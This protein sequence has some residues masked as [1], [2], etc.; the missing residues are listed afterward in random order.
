MNSPVW[1]SG[2]FLSPLGCLGSFTLVADLTAVGT[3]P[4]AV[5]L[6]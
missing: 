2:V 1:K 5:W 3:V 6:R 4:L